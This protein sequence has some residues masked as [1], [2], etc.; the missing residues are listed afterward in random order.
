MGNEVTSVFSIKL[1]NN[2]TDLPTQEKK[3][4]KKARISDP[5][6]KNFAVSSSERPLTTECE[7]NPKIYI[8][9]KYG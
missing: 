3:K 2:E 4:I 7:K 1:F 6:R 9:V 8:L 5:E